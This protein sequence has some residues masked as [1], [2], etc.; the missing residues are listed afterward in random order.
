VI[1]KIVAHV[2]WS[3]QHIDVRTA[4]MS[5]FLN[6]EVYLHRPKRFIMHGKKSCL[7]FT[8]GVVWHVPKPTCQV[9]LDQQ[10]FVTK[11]IYYK[12]G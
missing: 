7:L 12:L 4:F 5:N 11:G 3:I 10:E 2:D 9:L 1:T 8:K 6:E